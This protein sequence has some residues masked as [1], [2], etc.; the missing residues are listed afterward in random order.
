MHLPV[1]HPLRRFYRVLAGLIGLYVLLFGVIGF[2]RTRGTE[3][4]ANQG[5]WVLGLS[6][7]PAFS[8][9]SVATGLLLLAALLVGRNLDH[10]LN[11]MAGAVFLFAGIAMLLLLRT[12]LNFLAFTVTNCVVSFVFGLVVLTAGLYGKV[13]PADVAVAEDEFRHGAVR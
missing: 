11:I 2:V 10:V 8:L 5:E 12:D 1:N 9:L 13:G 4:F 7:N 6:T 3:F